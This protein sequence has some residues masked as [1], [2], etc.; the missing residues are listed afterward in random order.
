VLPTSVKFHHWKLDFR[1]FSFN[2]ITQALQIYTIHVFW[3]FLLYH[4]A[5]VPFS[6]QIQ[7]RCSP[8]GHL[9]CT[10]LSLTKYFLTR[11][12]AHTFASYGSSVIECLSYTPS[13]FMKGSINSLLQLKYIYFSCLPRLCILFIPH[14]RWAHDLFTATSNFTFFITVPPSAYPRHYPGPLLLRRSFPPIACG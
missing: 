6:F 14:L 11:Y 12:M 10:L 5:L 2:L 3:Y 7:V 4:H 1:Q 13:I 8:Q 9:L